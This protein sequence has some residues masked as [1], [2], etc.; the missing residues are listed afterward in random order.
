ME[1]CMLNLSRFGCRCTKWATI[2]RL[3]LGEIPERTTFIQPGLREAL[4]PYFELTNVSSHPAA[5]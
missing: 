2:V 5:A 4:K 3:L 1:T